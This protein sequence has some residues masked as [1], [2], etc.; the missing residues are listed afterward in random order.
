MS[1]DGE[2]KLTRSGRSPSM[3]YETPE[4]FVAALDGLAEEHVADDAPAI[5]AL[6][7]LPDLRIA[8]TVAAADLR[9]LVVLRDA[10]PERLEELRALLRDAA[11]SDEFVGR[12]RYVVL[13][14]DDDLEG[15]EALE[16]KPGISVVQAEAFGRGG[17]V[18]AH[19]ALDPADTRVD[20]D[21]TKETPLAATLS[22]GLDAFAVANTSV[23]DH[24]RR[25]RRDGI[26]WVPAIEVTD[27]GRRR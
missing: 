14:D 9:P 19:V 22:A 5:R 2:R 4:A 1:A 24:L 6:P 21:P 3:V 20:R 17:E 12:F 15:F 27:P 18:L 16:L 8:L 7:A 26:E 11:W 13:D 10:D 23:R 25:G